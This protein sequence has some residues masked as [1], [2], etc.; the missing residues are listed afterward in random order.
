MTALGKYCELDTWA[1]VE[2]VKSLRETIK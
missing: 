2:I 1:E